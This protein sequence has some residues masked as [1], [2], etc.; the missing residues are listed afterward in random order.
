MHCG[1]TLIYSLIPTCIW[2][3][4]MGVSSYITRACQCT[5]SVP[6]NRKVLN[7]NMVLLYWWRANEDRSMWLSGKV[8]VVQRLP[9]SETAA[10]LGR[11]LVLVES[12]LLFDWYRLPSSIL[13]T[14][15]IVQKQAKLI[16]IPNIG[17]TKCPWACGC[18]LMRICKLNA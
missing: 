7:W 17:T 11:C 4:T 6:K 16:K 10:S 9:A 15:R 5:Y 8:P 13:S 1:M 2:I 18:G 14:C 3:N 12:I